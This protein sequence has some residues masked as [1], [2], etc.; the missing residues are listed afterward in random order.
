MIAFVTRESRIASQ[1]KEEGGSAKGREERTH[2]TLPSR[3]KSLSQPLD[4][5]RHTIGW[6]EETLQVSPQLEVL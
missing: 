2:H 4:A 6:I 3:A 5:R 1:G